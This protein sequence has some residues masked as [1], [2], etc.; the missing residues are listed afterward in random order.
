[1]SLFDT[2]IHS[3]WSKHPGK[4]WMARAERREGYWRVD[5]PKLVG[6][7]PVFLDEAFVAGVRGR[8]LLGFDFPIGV[9]AA[10]G[11]RTGLGSFLAALAIFGTGEWAAFF[12]VAADLHEVR[13]ER[14]FYPDKSVKGSK[15]PP[16]VAALGFAHFD[17]LRRICERRDGRKPAG[18]L[19]W[20]LGGNQVGKAALAGWQ[21]IIRPAMARGARLWPYEGDLSALA[22]RS[23]VVLAET[24]PAEA[25][26]VVGAPF[27]RTESKRRS[28]DRRRKAD[29]VLRWAA[30][31]EVKLSDAARKTVLDGFG[32]RSSGED[33]FD[34]FLGLL[35][36]IEIA[37]GRLPE[38]SERHSGSEH[39]EGWILGR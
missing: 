27:L 13:L 25:Y 37:D 19:F 12:S 17:E 11:V 15:Q 24:Y 28:E 34:A 6:P 2:L 33:A 36:M 4:R 10:Y 1:M 8:V 3:D 16:F 26:H 30:R 32:P 7:C 21:E 22:G 39:W 35:K 14:P 20:T 31:N 38:Q 29:P 5:A 9:P 18:T 23:G